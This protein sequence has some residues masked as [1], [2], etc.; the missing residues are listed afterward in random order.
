MKIKEVKI[1][2]DCQKSGNQFMVNSVQQGDLNT[3]K[4]IINLFNGEEKF[5]MCENCYAVIYG[6]KPDGNVI[7]NK[8]EITTEGAVEYLLQQQDTSVAGVVE[9][10]LVITCCKDEEVKVLA[11]PCFNCY[12]Q[13]NAVKSFFVPLEKKP[14]D[15]DDNFN[16]YFI[17]KNGAYVPVENP[18]QWAEGEIFA[19]NGAVE[20]HNNIGVLTN[21]I[22]KVQNVTVRGEFIDKLSV[23]E[24]NLVVAFANGESETLGN[25]QGEKGEQ[26]EQGIQGIQGEK[27]ADGK[28][29]AD[30]KS[31]Y[32]YAQESGYA[33]TETEFASD[34]SDVG[35]VQSLVATSVENEKGNI[36]NSILTQL[37]GLPVFGVVDENNQI[38]VTSQL[39]DGVY[40]L[41]YENADGTYSDIG[42]ITVGS[43]E[44]PEPIINYIPISTESTA[45]G[46][47]VY[48]G[49][50]Y[51]TDTR[52]S[53]STGETKNQTGFETTGFIP[54]K[55]GDTLYFKNIVITAENYNAKVLYDKDGNCIKGS[56]LTAAPG[57]TDGTTV[58]S[59][60]IPT[61][62]GYGLSFENVAYIRIS[63]SEI[64]ADSIIT[65]NQ[66]IE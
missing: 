39:S 63:A 58:V 28:D 16:S 21:L 59:Y 15:W 25:V 43:G 38:T 14:L 7:C 61:D 47:A 36:I 1:N 34:L 17:A 57:V 51:K 46:S 52:L 13:G 66:P 53:T 42:T 12:V 26:G 55:V 10:Q 20:S 8:C 27:G 29:G 24:G 65:V 49:N 48:N 41:K 22:K 4:F 44:K 30:G 56:Y 11:S 64:T 6:L 23:N 33:G 40:T 35:N 5:E 31:A 3:S 2:L 32:A 19:C 62:D 50:G 9:Y 18:E 54:V 60:T 37:Q 45:E